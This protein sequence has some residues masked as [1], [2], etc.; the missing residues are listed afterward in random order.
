MKRV[1]QSLV[2]TLLVVALMAPAIYLHHIKQ[3]PQR[4]GAT[5]RSWIDPV[6][7][8]L[9]HAAD[10]IMEKGADIAR[11]KKIPPG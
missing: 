3:D 5:C 7:N 4:C 10:W 2:N 11:S 1:P 6:E 9:H 8:V